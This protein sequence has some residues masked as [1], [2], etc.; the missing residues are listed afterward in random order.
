MKPY[1]L[2]IYNFIRFTLKKWFNCKK[3][4]Y[5]MIEML[6]Y[7]MKIK[8]GRKSKIQFGTNL[9]SDGRGSIIIDDNGELYIGNKVYFNDGLMISC[10]Q[11]VT[12]GEECMFGPNVKIFDNDHKFDKDNGVSSE[13]TTEQIKIGKSCWIASNVV[14]LKGTEIGDNCVIGAGCVVQGKIPRASIVTQDRKL[15][16]RPIREKK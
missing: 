2:V 5:S 14:I 4:Q 1:V 12:I 9:V 11:K 10:K 15:L 6:N 7:Q 3:F 8:N 16:I 13:H